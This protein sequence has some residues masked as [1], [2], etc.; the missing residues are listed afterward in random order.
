M[1]EIRLCPWLTCWSKLCVCKE[2]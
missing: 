2:N 1:L